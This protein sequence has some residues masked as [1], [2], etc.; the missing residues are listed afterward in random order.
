MLH[1]PLDAGAFVDDLRE[2]LQGQ[3][4]ALNE[5]LPA[6]SGWRSANARAGQ[7]SSHR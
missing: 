1:K 4:A 7:S 6:W 5:E 3:L 2:Q